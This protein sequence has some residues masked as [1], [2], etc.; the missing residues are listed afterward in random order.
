M[1]RVGVLGDAGVGKT[2]LVRAL[3]AARS[4][5]KTRRVAGDG[6]ETFA[7]TPS[8]RRGGAAVRVGIYRDEQQ[9]RKVVND[10]AVAGDVLV[11]LF[12]L[13]RHASLDSVVAQVC[14]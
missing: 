14:R 4:P 13:T 8:G 10:V 7:W 12:D 9:R 2:S 5:L 3:G 6:V 11:L 1:P